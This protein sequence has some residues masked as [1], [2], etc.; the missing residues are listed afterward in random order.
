MAKFG[1]FILNRDHA[2]QEFEGEYLAYSSQ[3]ASVAVAVI[4]N[5][6]KGTD[7]PF[8]VIRLGEGQCVKEIK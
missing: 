4:H 6:G 1:F 7:Y 8:A 5:D 2:E 3:G